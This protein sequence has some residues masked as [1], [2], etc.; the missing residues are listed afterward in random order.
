MREVIVLTLQERLLLFVDGQQSPLFGERRPVRNED[1]TWQ[2]ILEN[3]NVSPSEITMLIIYEKFDGEFL[4]RIAKFLSDIYILKLTDLFSMTSSLVA[5]HEM[6]NFIFCGCITQIDNQG[7]R[8]WKYV[9]DKINL[10][11]ISPADVFSQVPSIEK[12]NNSLNECR[13]NLARN[14]NKI[15]SLQK[16]LS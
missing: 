9:E 14:T 10:P 11:E 4:S 7:K 12:L 15:K 5:L 2:R 13:R 6:K 16:K 8:T 1:K 3:I